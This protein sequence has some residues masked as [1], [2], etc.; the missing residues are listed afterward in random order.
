MSDEL[1]H[2]F[3]NYDLDSNKNPFYWIVAYFIEKTDP[4]EQDQSY[5]ILFENSAKSRKLLRKLFSF[6]PDKIMIWYIEHCEAEPS[7]F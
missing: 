1:S 3:P 5:N 4:F 7:W 2:V 6:E